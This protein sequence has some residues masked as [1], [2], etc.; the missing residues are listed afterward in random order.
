MSELVRLADGTTVVVR[1]MEPGDASVVR[2][3]FD[4]LSP[5]SLRLRFFSPVPRLTAGLAADLVRVSPAE[6][7]VLLAIDPRTGRLAGEAR[8]VRLPSDPAV[9]DL[10]VTVSDELQ[11]HGL[12]TALVRAVRRE[13]RRQGVRTLTG[14][15]LVDN[16]GALAMLRAGGAVLEFDEPGVY[17]F[18][19]ELGETAKI[20]G[21]R[22]SSTSSVARSTPAPV[23]SSATGS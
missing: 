20:E 10:A 17:A 3:G 18:R 4:H 23:T 9:A 12:G 13:A 6:R 16:P 11:R 14:N 8:A 21:W 1:P 2:D 19:I 5:A 22:R 15:V 7:I